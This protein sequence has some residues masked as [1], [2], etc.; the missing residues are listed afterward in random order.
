MDISDDDSEPG[1]FQQGQEGEA[2]KS[3]SFVNNGLK[4]VSKMI[5][6]NRIHFQR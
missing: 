6:V 4:I 2:S 1:E 5:E 3:S